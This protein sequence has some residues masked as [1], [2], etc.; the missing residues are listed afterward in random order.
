M[1]NTGISANCNRGWRAAKGEWVKL[2]AGDDILSED[3]IEKYIKYIE[4]NDNIRV[5]SSR[6]QGFKIKEDG[7]HQHLKIHP[8][9]RSFKFFALPANKQY[10]WLLT[11]SFNI[12]PSTILKKDVLEDL[13]GFDEEF[14]FFEDLPLWLNITK[15][16]IKMDFLPATTVYYRIHNKSI[17]IADKGMFFNLK[18]K[19]SLLYFKRKYIYPHVPFYKLCFWQSEWAKNTQYKTIIR[20]FSNKK[21]L[22]S[23]LVYYFFLFIN[24]S[25]LYIKLLRFSKTG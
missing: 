11:N 13:D 3:C 8:H 7:S 14:P 18:F 24:F 12:A 10:H 25:S 22:V 21:S 19:D 4:S 9:K 23:I 6:F 15:K 2:I 17:R 16:N 5:L 20:L 1:H